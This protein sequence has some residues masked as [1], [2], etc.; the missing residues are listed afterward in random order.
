MWR[1]LTLPPG[2]PARGWSISAL[3]TRGD[4]AYVA[5]YDIFFSIDAAI[6]RYI[7]GQWLPVVS[8]GGATRLTPLLAISSTEML[9]GGEYVLS[10]AAT[11]IFRWSSGGWISE[12]RLT[13]GTN[14]RPTVRSFVRCDDGN[15]MATT[16][17]TL[18]LS[19]VSNAWSES[20]ATRAIGEFGVASDVI[21]ASGTDYEF[22]NGQ[23][24]GRVSG[25]A[26]T[27][28]QYVLSLSQ[29]SVAGPSF[30]VANGGVLGTSWDGVRWR[31]FLQPFAGNA[32]VV[33]AAFADGTATSRAFETTGAFVGGFWNYTRNTSVSG[34]EASMW[35]LSNA[36]LALAVTGP[37]T[38]AISR[39]RIVRNGLASDLLPP[40]TTSQFVAV[41]G[42]SNNAIM[43]VGRCIET[44]PQSACV[45]RYDGTQTI[46]Q[47]LGN[48]AFN[49]I[50]RD[51]FVLSSNSAI[52]VGQSGTAFRLT[53]VG[54]SAIPAPTTEDFIAVT[55]VS[56]NE[57]YAFTASGVLYGFDGT[58]WQLL[59]RFS[60]PVL[61]ARIVGTTAIA[62]GTNGMIVYG[63]FLGAARR[64]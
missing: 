8:P 57:V 30:A 53:S 4:T 64:P 33:Y 7:N 28:D 14:T 52:A 63:R 31:P 16:S 39:F 27:F 12:A 10:G 29:L 56:A 42:A 9:V 38:P 47:R 37:I 26:L 22:G 41:H 58:S 3:T 1:S 43:A 24:R 5:V 20:G 55:G 13:L 23:L 18:A 54:W 15:F 25:S 36:A 51:V 45:A 35:G 34:F 60:R 32:T 6:L 44:D 49:A 46:V 40:T 48:P 50:L 21:C 2:G 11:N 59:Q 17:A 19:R 61:S 62:V